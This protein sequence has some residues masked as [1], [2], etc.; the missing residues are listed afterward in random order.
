MSTSPKN[1]LSESEYLHRERQSEVKH[2]FYNGEIFA[3][4]GAS[5][6]HNIITGNVFSFLRN[7]LRGGPCRPFTGDMRLKVLDNGLYTYPDIMIVCRQPEFT[8]DQPDTVTNPSVIME[9]LSASTEAYDRGK[10][11]AHYRLIPSLEAY[12]LIS[13][14]ERKIEMFTREKDR[15]AFLET[16]GENASLTIPPLSL[17]LPLDEVYEGLEWL[18]EE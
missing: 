13:Q 5:A 11:F 6:R 1:L 4:T 16:I 3:M 18:G 10:K 14:E 17:K 7:S 15:W 8:G 2:E 9:T 12:L